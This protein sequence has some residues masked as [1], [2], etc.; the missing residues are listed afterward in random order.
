MSPLEEGSGA[1]D[2]RE[3]FYLGDDVYAQEADGM[4]LLSTSDGHRIYLEPS[5]YHALVEYAKRAWGLA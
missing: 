1:R 4:I 2:L 5:V 3:R